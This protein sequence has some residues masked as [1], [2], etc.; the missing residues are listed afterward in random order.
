[1]RNAGLP[2]AGGSTNEFSSKLWPLYG[3]VVSRV[4]DTVVDAT[5]AAAGGLPTL[6]AQ[7]HG[8]DP[9]GDP[10]SGMPTWGWRGSW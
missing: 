6:P 8:Y 7:V 4:S 5:E 1:M 9:G 2:S 10:R 3:A